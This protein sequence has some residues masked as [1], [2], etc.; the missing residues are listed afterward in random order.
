MSRARNSSQMS[1]WAPRRGSY[2]L[3]MTEPLDHVTPT[4]MDE[5]SRRPF[6]WAFGQLLQRSTALDT[7]MHRI[8][9]SG[10][11]LSSAEVRGIS[12]MRI[13][14][15]DINARTLEEEAFALLRDPDR[16][17]NLTRILSLLE[18]G[19]M[20]L[21]SAPLAGWSPDF[22]VFHGKEGPMGIILGL[23]WIQRPF[24][25]RG[26]AWAMTFGPAEALV[27]SRRFEELWRGAHEIGPAIRRLLEG[28]R[29]RWM[30]ESRRGGSTSFTALLRDSGEGWSAR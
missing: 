14:V 28:A 23:H 1:I 29:D 8:R 10:V 17:A 15:A 9:L 20:E 2:L 27:G 21:R 18:E 6:R 24:P 25:H 3:S 13:L 4:L 5:R 12:R 22:S 11:D 26:P 30:P 7:A 16:H 19:R